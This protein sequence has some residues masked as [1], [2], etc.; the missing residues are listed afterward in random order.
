[1]TAT[2]ERCVYLALVALAAVA[3]WMVVLA[4]A[5]ALARAQTPDETKDQTITAKRSADSYAAVRNAGVVV[6][7]GDSLWSISE[8]HLGPRANPSDVVSLV[9][10]TYALNRETIGADPSLLLAGQRLQLPPAAR[11]TSEITQPA[12]TRAAAEAESTPK[13]A[14]H[15]EPAAANTGAQKLR[16]E[17]DPQ[18]RVDTAEAPAAATRPVD[19]PEVAESARSLAVPA[20]RPVASDTAAIAGTS[21]LDEAHSTATNVVAGLVE[22]FPQDVNLQRRWVGYNIILL[23]LLS[24]ALMLWKLPMKRPV[25]PESWGAYPSLHHRYGYSNGDHAARDPLATAGET[26]RRD[27]D[28]TTT[29]GDGARPWGVFTLARKRRMGLNERTQDLGSRRHKRRGLATSAYNPRVRSH[30]RNASPNASL[31][32]THPGLLTTRPFSGTIRRSV[33]R[34]GVV[35]RSAAARIRR[36]IRSR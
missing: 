20:A 21:F 14:I 12:T 7:P 30:L 1:M 25:S 33:V 3:M 17:G 29:F 26:A 11:G 5:P 4:G 22:V 28:K 34:Y 36:E 2:I 27:K 18:V 13:A 23:T 35:G 15:Y 32:K 6:K 24:A 9:E 16:P 8:R 10:G 31:R 19:L